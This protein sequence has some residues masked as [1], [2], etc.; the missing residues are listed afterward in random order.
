MRPYEGLFVSI[1]GCDGSGKTSVASALSKYLIAKG[2]EVLRTREPGGTPLSEHIRDLLLRPDAFPICERAE[3]LLFLTARV[4]NLRDCIMP[5]LR[6]GKVVICERF[7]D[8]TIAYQAYA[9]HLSISE[10]T[11][12]CHL[13][14]EEVEPDLTLLLDVPPQVGLGRV[15]DSKDRLEQERIQ[16]HEEVRGGFLRLADSHPNRI[17]VIDAAKGEGEVLS[18]AILAVESRLGGVPHQKIPSH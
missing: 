17:V 9:R 11:Q 7:N 1:E 14:C 15:K 18:E 10:V 6:N 13:V 8:S 16:F 5:A 2:Y 4:Q 12:I 3:M